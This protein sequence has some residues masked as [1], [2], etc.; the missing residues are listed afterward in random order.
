MKTLE[1]HEMATISGGFD[2]SCAAGLQ[3]TACLVESM[4]FGLSFNDAAD[5][6]VLACL[7]QSNPIQ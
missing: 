5:A 3:F 2:S 6:C 7:Y 1:I 4:W